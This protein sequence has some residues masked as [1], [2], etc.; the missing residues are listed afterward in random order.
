MRTVHRCIAVARRLR[1]W[2][3]PRQDGGAPGVD[4]AEAASRSGSPQRALRIDD[5]I[6]AEDPHNVTALIN[7]GEAQTASQQP[8]AAAG[9]YSEA[10]RLDPKSVLARI[11]LGWLRLAGDPIAAETL[12]L[13]ALQPQPHNAVA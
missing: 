1:Q 12:F 10:L 2:R 6:L 5:A 3:R 7:R 9:S 13:E 8:D 4:V 11:G